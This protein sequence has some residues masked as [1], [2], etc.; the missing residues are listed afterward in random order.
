METLLISAVVVALAE[1]GD[2]TQLLAIVLTARFKQPVPIIIGIFCATIA[3]HL[4]A[5]TGGYFL[6]DFL[7]G[8]WFQ[9][10]I[11]AS[12]I[13]MAAWTLIPD[14]IA[15]TKKDH[16]LANAFIA[17]LIAFFLIEMGDKTQV[18]TVALAARFHSVFLVAVGTTTG[19]L[20]ADVPAVLLAERATNFVP[21]RYVRVGAAL[22]FFV[23]GLWQLI[24]I[25]V[26]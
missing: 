5:A 4:L 3:N 20:I 8:I 17:T 2:K 21:L 9:Y 26:G 16:A 24:A 25:W 18:A 10:L 12:F 14:E 22:L 15:E 1:I 13:A 19:M 6:S 7:S 23:L 11:A